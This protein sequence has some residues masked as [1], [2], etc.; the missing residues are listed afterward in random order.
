MRVLEVTQ[1]KFY[2][3]VKLQTDL[4]PTDIF[5]RLQ[6]EKKFLLESTLQHETKGKYSFIGSSP[7]QEIIGTDNLT[8]VID[9]EQ[10]TKETVTQ[11]A[12]QYIKEQMP[13]DPSVPPLP[14]YGGAIGYVGYDAIRQFEDIGEN[15]PDDIGMP[16]VHFMLYKTAVVVDHG[17]DDV[18][19]IATNPSNEPE[20]ILDKRLEQLRKSLEF[21]IEH[22]ET[23]LNELSFQP[24]ISEDVFKEKTK[25][26]KK[27]IEN[28]E[29]LQV[30]LSQRMT[31][32]INGDP[33][34]YYQKL[35]KANPSPY[36]FYINFE[37]YVIFGTSPE[38][39]IQ[40]TGHTV[41]S[42]P[43]AGTRPR[44]E[45]ADEDHALMMELL[46][47]KKE[48]AEHEMLV[49]LSRFDL[50]TVCEKGSIALPVFMEVEKYEHVMHLVSEVHGKL[51]KGYSS[52]D[53]L[54][55]CLPAGTVSGAPKQRAMQIINELEEK[56]RGAYGGGVGYI[57]FHHDLNMALTIRSLIVK[58]GKAY[59]QAGAGIVQ[60]SSP[61]KEY[62]ETLHKARSLQTLTN[63]RFFKND[64]DQVFSKLS[65][66]GGFP[67]KTY[68]EKLI[69]KENLTVQEMKEA[70]KY[71]LSN[72]VTDS[73]I[74]AFLTALQAKGE[75]ADEITGLVEVIRAEANYQTSIPNTIDNCGTGGDKSYSF[76]IST[77][78]AF[79]IAGCGVRVAKHG[80]R[81]ISSK[82]GSADV[83][84]HLGV[85]LSFTSE[86]VEESLE[87]NDIAFLYAPHVHQALKPFSKVRKDLGIPTIFNAIGPLTNPIDLDTQLLGAYRKDLLPMLAEVLRKLGRR[88]AIVVTGAGNMDEASLIGE[89]ELILVDDGELIPFTLTPEEVGLSRC[90][91]EDI[92]GG[93][94]KQNA[95]ILL[96][97][98]NGKQGPYLDT[99]LLNAG[100]GLYTN[101]KAETIKDGIE[102]AR[103]SIES[104]AAKE[105][106]ERL[107][108]YSKKIPSEVL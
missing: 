61:Q 10:N 48:I 76:N 102:M 79:V 89:N 39:F 62:E 72:D 24:E 26:A 84:E 59:L 82:T 104:G 57:N 106:L 96:D 36:M 108:E 4:T 17:N 29:V 56:K 45:T 34:L 53:A 69:H 64:S 99:V 80:N 41:I 97:V 63:E 33:F 27:H 35:R 19:L 85:S 87:K 31:S 18:Y 60:D 50:S 51:K 78:S 58:D 42:N 15:L 67:M 90:T 103:E 83:L 70:T 107:I 37:D 23:S 20:E 93:D 68:I 65:V 6:G 73:E 71:C 2:K 86:Q 21:A 98:L 32:E 12:L 3:S 38:S 8:T 46:Q 44:G 81:S 43:I 28:G 7:Y 30:V 5:R 100:L 54:I 13:K 40:T 105:R 92:R 25:I 88:R 95:E 1:Q 22:T 52:I 101:G 11:H 94:A 49:D 47:D 14:F 75:T 55:A 9:Y 74:A 91:K 16:D 66:K 77:T